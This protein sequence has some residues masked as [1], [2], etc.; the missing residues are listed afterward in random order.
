MNLRDIDLRKIVNESV[1]MFLL[2]EAK[3]SKEDALRF[4]EW[5]GV[6]DGYLSDM[7][8]ELQSEYL[9]RQYNLISAYSCN[10]Y[11]Y[12]FYIF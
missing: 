10:V 2:H 7:I 4:D 12:S 9:N 6:F 1:N 5:K 8:D 3:M 11:V